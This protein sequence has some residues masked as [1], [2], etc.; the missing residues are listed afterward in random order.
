MTLQ[1]VI[2]LAQ[3]GEGLHAEFKKKATHPEKIVREII[4]MANTE[5]GYLFIGVDDDGT[6]SGHRYIEEE[7][8]VM[9]KAI[10]E[11]VFPA[12]VFRKNIIP[13]NE[14][15]GVAAYYIARSDNRPHFLI[16]D[17]KKKSYVRV[18]DRSIQASKEVWE[19]LK[20]E[21]NR[22]DII[23]K[24]GQKE[25]ILMKALSENQTITLKEYMKIAKLPVFIASK[26]LV[27]LVL[28][29]V[30]KV[31]PQEREDLFAFKDVK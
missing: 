24:Y 2:Q 13:F 18:K 21:K 1:E 3:K 31:I 8:Y 12:L 22:K 25:E 10:H 20:R 9:D 27:R 17:N 5:G 29:N 19:I 23:F 11:L 16:E 15:K 26:T 14:K 6:V 30:L 7:V 28:A 4:A